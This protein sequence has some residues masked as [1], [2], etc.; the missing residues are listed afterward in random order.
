MLI[1][2]I[3]MSVLLKSGPVR[4]SV[5]FAPSANFHSMYAWYGSSQVECGSRGG[6]GGHG[7]PD[8]PPPW[9]ITSHMGF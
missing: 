6:G 7:G 9:K 5:R 4:P 1:E 2:P 3:A 8:P